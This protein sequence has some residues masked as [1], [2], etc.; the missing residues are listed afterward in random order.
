MQLAFA[1][2]LYQVVNFKL[3]ICIVSCIYLV[4]LMQNMSRPIIARATKNGI[5]Q[6][7]ERDI[8]SKYGDKVKVEVK[9]SR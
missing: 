3:F 7:I 4:L 8:N 6:V 9:N 1:Y 5:E 2:S